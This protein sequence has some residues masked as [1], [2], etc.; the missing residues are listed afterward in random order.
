MKE[1]ENHIKK[2]GYDYYLT[3]SSKTAYIFK[4]V[5]GGQVIGY[6]VF[7]RIENSRFDCVSFPRD[8]AFGKWAW[9]YR[10][11]EKAQDKFNT[12]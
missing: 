11:L 4:Q 1:L 8:E 10:T 3:E 12:I 9:T 6:E 5:L 2:N 7:K